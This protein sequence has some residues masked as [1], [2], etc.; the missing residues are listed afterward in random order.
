V[1]LDTPDH[2]PVLTSSVQV[3]N[4]G[5]SYQPSDGKQMAAVDLGGVV[6]NDKGKPVGS[7][8]TRLN[9]KSL[10][11]DSKQSSASIYNYRLPLAPGL[12]QVR[13]ATRDN[14]SGRVGSAHQW[15]EIPNLSLGKLQLS[16]LL[17]GL[18]SVG[19]AQD[20]V[21]FS[22]DHRFRVN[23]KLGF[24]AFIYNA[25]PGQGGQSASHL[26]FQARLLRLGQQVIASNWQ[27]VSNASQDRARILFQG[28]LSLNSVPAGRYII[29][30]NVTD[31]VSKASATQQALITIE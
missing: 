20:Q 27:K 9:I 1:F 7:F 12:Y 18:Q 28:E 25:A 21:Q 11:D 10:G 16:S 8:Q 6:V 23:T 26:S 2:G 19:P 15:I 4:D 3:G 17:M 13:V 31:E 14:N 30:L 5:L 29:E 24:M 22:V